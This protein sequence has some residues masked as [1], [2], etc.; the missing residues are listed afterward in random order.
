MLSRIMVGTGVTC[1]SN[2]AR[3]YSMAFLSWLLTRCTL[4]VRRITCSYHQ[5]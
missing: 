2:A 4:S 1:F 5:L 3:L